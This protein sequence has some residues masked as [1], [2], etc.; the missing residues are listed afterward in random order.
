MND[1]VAAHRARLNDV[2]GSVSASLEMDSPCIVE[3]LR[4]ADR[5]GS[6]V[7]Q[8]PRDIRNAFLNPSPWFLVAIDMRANHAYPSPKGVVLP[9]RH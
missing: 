5:M 6:S 9:F 2:I 8:Q 1:E 4:A 7:Y 3:L